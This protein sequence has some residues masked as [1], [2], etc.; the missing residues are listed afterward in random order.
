MDERPQPIFW[1]GSM[2]L[3]GNVFGQED[4]ARTENFLGPVADTDLAGT[5]ESDA[6]L[7]P[8]R[9]VP[10]VQIVAV[11]VVL[12][13]QSFDRECALKE[14]CAFALIELF[15]VRFAIFAG[16]HSTELHKA[17]V[18]KVLLA[19]TSNRRIFPSQVT[20]LI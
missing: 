7:A 12:E 1:Q 6:P 5:G 2:A 19:F 15:E 8:R 3:A 17:S 14:F 16:I 10:A 20:E 13:H 9:I 4:V 11:L 18:A